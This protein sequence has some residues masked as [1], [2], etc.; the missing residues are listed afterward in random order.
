MRQMGWTKG[1]AG[2]DEC[3]VHS[4]SRSSTRPAVDETGIN[5]SVYVH[6]YDVDAHNNSIEMAFTCMIDR[7]Q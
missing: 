6:T 5:K 2:S 7:A 1:F 3:T 4:P